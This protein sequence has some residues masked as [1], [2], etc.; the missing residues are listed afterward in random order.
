[1]NKLEIKDGYIN[2]SLDIF[3]FREKDVR[4]MYSP[5]LDL[6]GYGKTVEEAKRSFEVVFK[7]YLNYCIEN[8]TLDA[9]LIK[10]GWKRRAAQS[11]YQSPDWTSMIRSNTNL[12]S[13][14]QGN[15]NKVSRYIS[16]PVSC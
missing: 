7:E 9:D 6:S 3:S 2:V 11:D 15:F 4:I 5:A 10:H 8:N 13:V 16:V 14:L 12:R 1:M